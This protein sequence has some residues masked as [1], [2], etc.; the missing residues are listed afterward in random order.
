MGSLRLDQHVVDAD[1]RVPNLVGGDEAQGWS[2][3][4]AETGEG[5]P[6]TPTGIG[7]PVKVH[8]VAPAYPSAAQRARIEGVVVLNATIGT[9]GTVGAIEVVRGPGA[10]RQAAIHAVQQWL[11]RPAIVNGNPTTMVI[12]VE[13]RFVMGS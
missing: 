1:S 6:N 11:Y 3:I 7:V 13:L 2:E 9:D 12:S 5:A 8:H 10:L 4:G